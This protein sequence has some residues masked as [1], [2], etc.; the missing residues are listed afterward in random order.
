MY[1]TPSRS[2]VINQIPVLNIRLQAVENFI[3]MHNIC[4]RIVIYCVF[5]SPWDVHE[6]FP[7]FAIIIVYTIIMLIIHTHTPCTRVLFKTKKR[8][9]CCY[10]V[11]IMVFGQ[12]FCRYLLH[13]LSRA[14]AIVY[15]TNYERHQQSFEHVLNNK[16]LFDLIA[17]NSRLITS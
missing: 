16:A 9:D 17:L 5:T 8:F 13:Q 1:F 2:D 15:A 12:Y 11:I 6:F 4:F 14:T 10:N 3:F 7:R